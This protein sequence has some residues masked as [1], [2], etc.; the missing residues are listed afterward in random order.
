MFLDAIVVPDSSVNHRK[1]VIDQDIVKH[2]ERRF[3]GV[4]P[5]VPSGELILTVRYHSFQNDCEHS[6]QS[7]LLV[8]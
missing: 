6:L 5:A 4:L 8:Q 3:H 1:I 7:N 2:S